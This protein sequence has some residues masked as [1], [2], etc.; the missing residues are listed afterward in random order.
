MLVLRNLLIVQGERISYRALDVEQIGSVYEGNHG[1][2]GS[3]HPRPLHRLEEQTTRRKKQITTAV[4]LDALLEMPAAE[5]A[6]NGWR[7][8]PA[9]LPAQV[10]ECTEAADSE[11]ALVEAFGTAHQPRTLRW[12]A[13]SQEALS[14]NPPKNGAAAV[15]TTR[16]ALTRPIVEEALRPWMERCEYKPTAAQIAGLKILI[17]RWDQGLSLWRAAAT[18]QSS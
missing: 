13:G 2:C 5:S 7:T 16:R 10:S 3:T 12:A 9:Q 18:W 15:A 1:L 4:D 17:Q 11:D 6:R 14:S 8:K